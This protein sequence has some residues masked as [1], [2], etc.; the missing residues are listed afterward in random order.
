MILL[1]QDTALHL[2]DT[3][4][5]EKQMP[6]VKSMAE[7]VSDNGVRKLYARKALVSYVFFLV[8]K[9]LPLHEKKTRA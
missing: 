5:T 3:T 6:C 8:R 7:V 4:G 1:Q 9:P 2:C